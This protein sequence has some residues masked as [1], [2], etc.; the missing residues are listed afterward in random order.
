MAVGIAVMFVIGADSNSGEVGRYHISHGAIP[1]GDVITL[2]DTKTGEVWAHAAG[3]DGM[4][5]PKL[6]NFWNAK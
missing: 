4:G 5:E 6:Q 2:V 3:T 1:G